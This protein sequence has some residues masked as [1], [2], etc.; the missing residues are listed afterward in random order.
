MDSLFESFYRTVKKY[1][2]GIQKLSILLGK[3]E[4]WFYKYLDPDSWRKF[5]IGLLI[6]LIEITKNPALLER[7]GRELGYGIYKIPK[8]GISDAFRDATEFQNTLLIAATKYHQFYSSLLDK[9]DPADRQEIEKARKIIEET[10]EAIRKG[11]AALAKAEHQV[12]KYQHRQKD[13]FDDMENE[14]FSN[15]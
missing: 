2:P 7:I 8:K 14:D 11:M 5:P 10:I 9:V 4:W 13:L 15:D 1:A 3:G 6:P 12:L